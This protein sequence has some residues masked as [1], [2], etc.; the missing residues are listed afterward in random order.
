MG[1]VCLLALTYIVDWLNVIQVVSSECTF[2]VLTQLS[3]RGVLFCATD[4]K[5]GDLDGVFL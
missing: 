4:V 2:V 1:A 5:V 3:T